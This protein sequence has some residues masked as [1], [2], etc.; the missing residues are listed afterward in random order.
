MNKWKKAISVG[1]SAT[2]LASLFTVIAASSVLAATSV[3]GVGNVGRGATSTNAATFTFSEESVNC[4][5]SALGGA[6]A[7]NAPVDLF[8]QIAPKAPGLGTVQFVGTP[9]LV[10]PG[11]LGAVASLQGTLGVNDTLRIRIN[12]GD[13]FNKQQITVTGLKIKA[14]SAASLG[15]I[16]TTLNDSLPGAASVVAGSPTTGL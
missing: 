12:G 8:V 14:S 10:A 15:A 2:L 11:S 1:M 9:T 7:P 5:R 16:V 4:I 6:G 3:A 13:E